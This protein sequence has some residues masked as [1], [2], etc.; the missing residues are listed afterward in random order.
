MTLSVRIYLT[1]EVLLGTV[2]FAFVVLRTTVTWH[3]KNKVSPYTP[4]IYL[5]LSASFA[6]HNASRER[7]LDKGVFLGWSV[8]SGLLSFIEFISL[9]RNGS[10]PW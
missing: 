4:L 2:V 3:A 5:L 8:L 7:P 6:A 10:E 1:L 9:L